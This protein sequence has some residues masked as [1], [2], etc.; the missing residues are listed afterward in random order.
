MVEVFNPIDGNAFFKTSF[1]WLANLVATLTKSDFAKENEGWNWWR[2]SKLHRRFCIVPSTSFPTANGLKDG[3]PKGNTLWWVNVQCMIVR[4]RVHA[5]WRLSNFNGLNRLL[6]TGMLDQSRGC[7][8]CRNWHPGCGHVR[9]KLLWANN[10]W[11]SHL[12]PDFII[13]SLDT[14]SRYDIL[15]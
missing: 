7:L 2:K 1:R 14:K 10:L 11:Q 5:M 4:G 9:R 12:F 6:N 3:F 13:N 8:G 15:R